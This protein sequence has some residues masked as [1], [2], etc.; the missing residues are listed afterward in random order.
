MC[1]VYYCYYY[2]YFYHHFIVVLKRKLCVILY[3]GD[4]C[5]TFFFI[6]PS[7]SPCSA[8]PIDKL[9]QKLRRTER[10][11]CPNAPQRDAKRSPILLITSQRCIYTRVSSLASPV[12]AITAPISVW[13]HSNS[14]Y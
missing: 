8:T 12:A 11:F 6:I 10:I 14:T 1:P 7:L 9:Y 13:F 5:N 4:G 3:S 2:Y